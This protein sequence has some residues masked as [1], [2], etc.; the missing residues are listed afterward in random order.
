MWRRVLS[1]SPSTVP[2]NAATVAQ[3]RNYLNGWKALGSLL[4]SGRSLSGR[5]RNCCFLNT[6]SLR[7]ADASSAVGFDHDSDSRGLATVDWDG[8]GD[9]DFWITNR[10]SPRV[11]YLQNG[12][13]AGHHFLSL[14]LRGV[15]C[16]RDAI[17]ARVE[18]VRG[19]G[20]SGK[21]IQSVMAGEGFISQSSKWLHFGLGNDAEIDRLVIRWPDATSEEVRDLIADRR[22]E[23][24]QG[25]G[26]TVWEGKERASHL[27]ASTPSRALTSDSAR[28]AL[29]RR[30]PMPRVQYYDFDGQTSSLGDPG[31][32]PVLINLWATWC[33]PCLTELQD[34]KEHAEEIDAARVSI[35]AL[36]VDHADDEPLTYLGQ[37]K[38]TWKRLHLPFQAGLIDAANFELLE[39]VERTL[40]LKQGSLPIPTSFLLDSDGRLA[41]VYK[42]RLSVDQLLADVSRLEIKSKDVRDGA[43]PFRGQWLTRPFPPDVLSVASQM[44]GIARGADAFDYLSRFVNIAQRGT[45]EDAF[46]T[47]GATAAKVADTFNGTARL[48][49]HEGLAEQAALAFQTSLTYQPDSWDTRAE[50]VSL[51]IRLGKS[52]EAIAHSRE[53]L[54]LRQSHPL[55]WNNIAW[56]LATSEDPA[57]RDVDKAID[58]AEQI[59][60]TTK[61]AEPTALDTLAVAY[62]AAGRFPEAID[63]AEKAIR[64]AKDSLQRPDLA[65]QIE[66][67]L[68]L[69]R[70]GKAYTPSSDLNRR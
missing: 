28:V 55:P 45:R 27:A 47:F 25:S 9:L 30:L 15:T 51:L 7:F 16:N 60:A 42:G 13:D 58:L 18:L 36:N 29:A 23:I 5:E 67:R 11:R 44:V 61:H 1:Q 65:E 21:L 59:N 19:Q 50:L 68:R 17:G 46:E 24:V 40:V 62:A 37:I 4:H 26:P 2:K 69:Y 64:L 31:T 41:F 38:Q 70:T 57:I 10:T 34:W 8:D 63:T 48:L 56:V 32:Q 54:R 66:A 53:M 52:K 43:A 20:E 12:I 33:Q 39:I 49:V 35:L 3:T 6:G 22:Y 14:K